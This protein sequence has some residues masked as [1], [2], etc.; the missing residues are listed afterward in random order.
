MALALAGAFLLLVERERIG[1]QQGRLSLNPALINK[2]LER[3]KAAAQAHS[4]A[5]GS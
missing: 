2:S 4:L 3:D 5:G 1:Q